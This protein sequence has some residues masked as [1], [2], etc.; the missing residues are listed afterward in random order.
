MGNGI[1]FQQFLRRLKDDVARYHMFWTIA[2]RRDPDRV[3]D[4]RSLHEWYEEFERFAE[5]ERQPAAGDKTVVR[6]HRQRRRL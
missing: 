5:E 2:M 6:A 1:T 4:K 3:E